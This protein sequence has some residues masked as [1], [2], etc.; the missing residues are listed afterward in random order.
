[1][2]YKL[3]SF[4][5]EHKMRYDE[6]IHGYYTNF[7]TLFDD[8]CQNK[9]LFRFEKE[10]ELKLALFDNIQKA[11]EIMLTGL[12]EAIDDNSFSQDGW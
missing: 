3:S 4:P 11:N 10:K 7:E 12:I 2:I 9:E 1:M 6:C 5:N 8:V